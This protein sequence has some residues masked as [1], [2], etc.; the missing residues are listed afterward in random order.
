MKC[1]LTVTKLLHE[2]EVVGSI[3]VDV[4]S[5]LCNYSTDSF[6]VKSLK[7][8]IRFKLLR[9]AEQNNSIETK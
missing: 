4:T 2:L 7:V 5:F 8:K 6:S 9:S 1:D 3:Q